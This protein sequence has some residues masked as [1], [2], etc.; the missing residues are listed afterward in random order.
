MK[1]DVAASVRGRLMNQAKETDRPFQ[2]LL[3][4]YAM[5]RFL[6][7]LSRSVY[8]DRFVLKG[9]LMFAVWGTAQSRATRDI[10]LLAR[11]DNSVDEMTRTMKDICDQSVVPD[12]VEFL[13]ETVKGVAIK[14]DADYAGVRVTFVAMIQ[15]AILPMQIDIE[16]GDVVHPAATI[17]EYPAMLDF[18][19]A[20][21]AG[22]PRETVIAEKFE[23]M[24]KLGLLNSRMK[25]FF[26]ILTLSRQF[27][28][29][30]NCLATAIRKTFAN[31]ATAIQTTPFAFSNAFA[32]DSSKQAQWAGF[33]RKSKLVGVPI[34]LAEVVQE[35]RIFLNPVA[36][37]IEQE[38]RFASH[39]HAG[40]SWTE[41]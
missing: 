33:L 34:S 5:E 27:D 40:G 24:T 32:D 13:A 12:G 35:I 38:N 26:D 11:A 17:V 7:R 31:R 3:Q 41:S 6:F 36:E 4:Y 1:R 19:S 23:A 14:E 21:I 2:E 29:D 28:F 9:A 37:A 25:D 8:V 16:V 30:G 10:D 18:E 20:K 15:N 22:Y 39:W